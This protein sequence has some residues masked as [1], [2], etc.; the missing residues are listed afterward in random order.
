MCPEWMK[1]ILRSTLKY[2]LK[3]SSF[4]ILHAPQLKFLSLV[5]RLFLFK[6]ILCANS[7]I[8]VFIILF[9]CLDVKLC[10]LLWILISE[11]NEGVWCSIG[12]FCTHVFLP[13][14][15]LSTGQWKRGRKFFAHELYFM[16]GKSGEGSLK[17]WPVYHAR[18]RPFKK[19]PKH[20][21]YPW[22]KWHGPKHITWVIFDTLNRDF[23]SCVRFYTLNT[24]KV[25]LYPTQAL[26]CVIP[27][28]G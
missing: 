2:K 16:I 6:K 20:G 1:I 22:L 15:D 7:Y 8:I 19:Y 27:K 23:C 13:P 9:W 10:I 14:P 18:P 4:Q 26:F 25:T 24:S 11:W 17:L 5:S 21:F 28:T 12:H 3:G